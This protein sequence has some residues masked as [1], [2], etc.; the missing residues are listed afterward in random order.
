MWQ[1]QNS[2]FDVGDHPPLVC[3]ADLKFLQVDEN[4]FKTFSKLYEIC[5]VMIVFI[6]SKNKYVCH[7]DMVLFSVITRFNIEISICHVDL[8]YFDRFTKLF[9]IIIVDV[10]KFRFVTS[11]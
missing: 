4:Y 10:N 5:L 2:T 8:N 9:E 7:V 6:D 1:R 11:T 3:L